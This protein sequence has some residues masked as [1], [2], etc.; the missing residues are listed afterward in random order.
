MSETTEIKVYKIAGVEFRLKQN[1]NNRELEE[2]EKLHDRVMTGNELTIKFT[3]DEIQK[4][5]SIILTPVDTAK[6]VPEGF[7]FAKASEEDTVEIYTAFFLMRMETKTRHS[8]RLFESFES[9]GKSFKN[10]TENPVKP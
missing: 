5:F 1:Y 9:Y 7:D 8:K 4:L 3:C 10:S 6:Q 2:I